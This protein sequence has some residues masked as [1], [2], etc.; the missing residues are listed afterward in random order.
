M[1]GARGRVGRDQVDLALL[2]PAD[3]PALVELETRNREQLLV[4][5]PLR[6]EDW[7]AEAGQRTALAHALAAKESGLGLPLGIR[8]L[9]EGRS[10]LVGRLTLAGITRG[11]FQSA[12][13]GY[14]VDEAETGR[15]IA[16][17]AVHLAVALAFGGLGL[18]RLQAEVQV[19]NDVSAR[20]LQRCGFTEYGLAP[21]YLRLGG[22]WS[23][24]R[25]FQLL[26]AGWV[27]EGSDAGRSGS[28]TG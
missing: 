5:A 6:D 25:M 22:E 21:S 11:A 3:V 10:R 24:C 15:G 28:R 26:D 27:P 16:T 19:G 7:F 12:S 23:D 13:L 1:S 8:L 4:G 17:R 2:A 18:H 14:W 20:V 9:E